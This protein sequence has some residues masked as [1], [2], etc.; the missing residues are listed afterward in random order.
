MLRILILIAFLIVPSWANAT[1]FWDDEMEQGNTN[2]SAAYMLSTLIPGGQMAY[3]TS[4]KYS[5]NA[6]VRLNYPVACKAGPVGGSQCGG[7]ISQSFPPTDELWRRAYFRMSGTGPN[8][9]S[10]G[11]FE[12]SV[13][14]FTKMFNA[15]SAYFSFGTIT[16]FYSRYWWIMGCCGS[17]AF[18]QTQ[19]NVPSQGHATNLYMNFTFSDNRWYCIETH[20]KMNTPGVA[21]G[22][23][24]A[25]V[26]GVRL[27][28]ASNVMWRPAGIYT[29][30]ISSTIIRQEGT[31]N[32]WYDRVA[33]GDSRI[34]CLGSPPP[35]DTTP[36]STPV[37]SSSVSNTTVTLT[38]PA[39]VDGGTGVQSYTLRRCLGAACIPTVTLA[40]VS[41]ST[42]SYIDSALANSSTYGYCLLAIDGV[43]LSSPCS[44]IKYQTTSAVVLATPPT[45]ASFSATSTSLTITDGAVPATY[46]RVQFADNANNFNLNTEY[47]RSS[48]VNGTLTVTIPD[49]T[50]FECVYPRDAAHLETSG[51]QKCLGAI[52][53]VPTIDITPVTMGTPFPSNPLPAGTTSAL[54]GVPINK[55]G[56]CRADT[57][58]RAYINM[59]ILTTA[60]Q[61]DVS[62]LNA[63]ATITGLTNGSSTTR[64]IQCER[65]NTF[66]DTYDTVTAATVTIAV[67]A[68]TADTTKPSDV[69]GVV[70]TAVPNTTNM[71]LTWNA[72]TDN[73]SVAFYRVYISS[74]SC[75][76]YAYS[77][78]PITATSTQLTLQN[79]TQYCFK[80]EAVDTSGNAS[81]NMSD[82]SGTGTATSASVPDVDPP[83]VPIGLSVLQRFTVSAQFG[84]TPGTDTQGNVFTELLYCQGAGCTNFVSAGARVGGT[85]IIVPLLV[86]TLYRVKIIHYDEAGNPSGGIN[87]PTYSEIVEVTTTATGLSTQRQDLP[88]G[89][90][91]AAA[92]RSAFGT[93]TL[94]P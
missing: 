37:L 64:Y 14:A 72:A 20:E 82:P 60:I 73:V 36:P 40:L 52:A 41:Q 9:T 59:D 85:S 61:M 79:N 47:P 68:S 65:V 28:G 76:L 24:E 32:I 94:R 33:T 38:W 15:Q 53:G 42:R 77:G 75:V 55:I 10:S 89:V 30:W 6:S 66:A 93:R 17:K 80:V 78:S 70:A 22:I 83:S 26:D 74:G 4:V 19:E 21:N 44:P 11:V 48:F 35:P 58:N 56:M 1:I 71:S 31:G 49:G 34:G 45:I 81:L 3:D 16:N 67:A 84:W 39:A 43:P 23:A 2:Y 87:N 51:N 54:F 88:F 62:N 8:P 27:N 63:S 7:G 92:I 29:Q 13:T 69:T 90:G 91:R 57:V 46:I 18:L 50:Q 12:T 86:N 25:W 5:G